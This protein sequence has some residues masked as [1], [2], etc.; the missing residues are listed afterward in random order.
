LHI[1]GLGLI[2]AGSAAC[3]HVLPSQL[4]M[5]VVYFFLVSRST[6]V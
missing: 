2:L 5:E 4:A 6:I 1:A 3:Y